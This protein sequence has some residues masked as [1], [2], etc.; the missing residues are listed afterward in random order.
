MSWR[1]VII[2]RP[3]KL[4]LKLNNMCVR[5]EDNLVRVNLDEMRLLMIE[6]TRVSIT[7]ALIAELSNKKIKVIFCDQQRNPVSELGFY[8]GCHD[9]PKKIL[10]QQSWDADFQDLVWT[11]IVREKIGNQITMLDHLEM[12]YSSIDKLKEYKNDVE[13]ADPTNREAMAARI[14]FNELF[15]KGFIRGAETATNA[16]LDY[17]Y[18]VLLSCF[19]REIKI[20]GYLTELGFFHRSQHN[21]YNLSSDLMET[22]R[23]LVDQIVYQNQFEIFGTKEKRIMLELLTQKVKI[24]NRKHLIPNAIK[25]YVNSVFDSLNKKDLEKIKHFEYDL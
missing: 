2:S 22:Y 12:P 24:N 18:Q 21:F 13:I 9:S 16:A 25:M 10:K 19:N 4:D 3:A 20:A 14:Y 23:P 17:G 8:Y 5:T 7:A 15:G 11:D 6:S 1:T